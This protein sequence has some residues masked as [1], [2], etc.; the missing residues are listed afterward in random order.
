[1]MENAVH[2]WQLRR[3][4]S[5]FF[6]HQPVSIAN[7]LFQLLE[8]RA[9]AKDTGYLWDAPDVPVA[10]LPILKAESNSLRHRKWVEAN[11]LHS[12]RPQV[13]ASAAWPCATVHLIIDEH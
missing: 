4:G 11:Y 5:L 8:R 13:P 12:E 3:W 10:I 6:E 1:M 7:V 2:F 9:L